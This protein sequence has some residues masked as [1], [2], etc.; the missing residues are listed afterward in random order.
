MGGNVTARQAA[1]MFLVHEKMANG[2]WPEEDVREL[3]RL[4]LI[5]KDGVGIHRPT[6]RGAACVRLLLNALGRVK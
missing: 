4:R 2:L 5:R 1:L 3:E 6:D